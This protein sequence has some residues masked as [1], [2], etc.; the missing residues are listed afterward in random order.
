MSPFLD[1]CLMARKKHVWHLPTFILGWAGVNGWGY[2]SIL[3][4]ISKCRGFVR[5]NARDQPNNGI[6]QN[7]SGKLTSGKNIVAN[8][9]LACNQMLSYTLINSFIMT[10]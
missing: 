7:S 4:G 2:Q 8:T 5:Q 10:T 3:K 1:F 6:A 9:D